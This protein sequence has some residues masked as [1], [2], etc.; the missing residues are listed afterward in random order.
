MAAS[1]IF[2]TLY[3]LEKNRAYWS[4]SQFRWAV[5]RRLEDAAKLIERI[6]LAIRK[7]SPDVRKKALQASR[8]KA[9]AI[10]DLELPVIMPEASTEETV[11]T[12]LADS[13]NFIASGRWDSLPETEY[14]RTKTRLRVT[15]EI[16]GAVLA[17]AGAGA[18]VGLAS[19]IGPLTTLFSPLLIAA[20]I[21]LFNMAG[22]PI[23]MIERYT[24]A[25]REIAPKS[26]DK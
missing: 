22:L 2:V 4:D 24:Q 18:L 10:R 14:V 21:A 13:L 7:V 17:L 15:V 25:G 8:R 23:S 5:A 11:M 6:P 3:I 16:A 9:Q 20:A 12:K 26:D 1:R 19:K